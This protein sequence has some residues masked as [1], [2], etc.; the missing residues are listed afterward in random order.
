MPSGRRRHALH[1]GTQMPPS[2]CALSN[3]RRAAALQPIFSVMRRHRK[4][5][6]PLRAAAVVLA[7]LLTAPFARAACSSDEELEV[8]IDQLAAARIELHGC[9]QELQAAKTQLAG[10]QAASK[11][12]GEPR[13]DA[14]VRSVGVIS[15]E[16]RPR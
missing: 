7:L 3:F 14:Q 9:R 13:I 5:C 16:G 4:G 2:R 12:A 6:G 1:S 11:A 8:M 15:P 10:L